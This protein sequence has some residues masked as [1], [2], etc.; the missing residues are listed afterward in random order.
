M[1]ESVNMAMEHGEFNV[2]AYFSPPLIA[3]SSAV[4]IVQVSG[5]LQAVAL[6]LSGT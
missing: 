6:D 3:K 4:T 2:V 5:N 1:S